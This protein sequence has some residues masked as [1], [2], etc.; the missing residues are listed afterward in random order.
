VA[1]TRAA[2]G[3]YGGGYGGL[4]TAAPD[5]RF[6]TVTQYYNNGVSNFD[7]LTVAYRHTYT[8][9]LTTQLHYTWSHTLGTVAFENPVN[10]TSGYGNLG[11][12]NRHQVAGDLAWTQS[13]KLQNRV[14]NALAHGWIFATKLYVYSGAPFS[15]TDSKIP[16]QAFCLVL[17]LE[18]EDGIVGVAHDGDLA[19]RRLPPY[20]LLS[21]GEIT[22]PVAV[23]ASVSGQT[24]SSMTPA[25]NHFRIGRRTLGSAILFS[26]S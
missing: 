22:T 21:N 15:V 26:M 4:P 6:V 23:P 10:I 11:F 8:F 1:E 19:T 9:G 25:F 2:P 5:A 16:S 20:P 13:H 18:A 3:G 24:P 7:G 17:V 14:A 12:D